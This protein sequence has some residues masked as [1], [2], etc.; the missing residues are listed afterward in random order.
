MR[1]RTWLLPGEHAL[2]LDRPTHPAWPL[3]PVRQLAGPAAPLPL[4]VA[5]SSSVPR[6]M[7]RRR[8]QSSTCLMP[9]ACGLSCEMVRQLR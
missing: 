2:L 3:A 9:V 7:C 1:K 8:V 5:A 4:S 6:Y